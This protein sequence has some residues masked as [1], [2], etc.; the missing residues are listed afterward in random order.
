LQLA[1]AGFYHIPTN[2]APDACRCFCCYKELD[3]WEP[4]DSPWWETKLW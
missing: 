1:D 2:D 4:E 3:G